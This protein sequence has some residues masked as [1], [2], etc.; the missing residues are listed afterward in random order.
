MDSN[1]QKALIGISVLIAIVCVFFVVIYVI[2][3]M[4]PPKSNFSKRVSLDGHHYPNPVE[5]MSDSTPHM[6]QVDGFEYNNHNSG[7]NNNNKR[8]TN[9]L[10]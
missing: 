1:L 4:N 2:I 8:V 5:P 9:N 3:Y 7:F 6:I 10:K